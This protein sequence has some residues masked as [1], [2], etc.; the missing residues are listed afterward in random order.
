MDY[1]LI[2]GGY[3]L[4]GLIYWLINMF[5]RKLPRKNEDGAGW[6]LSLFWLLLWPFCFVALICAAI[7]DL[8]KQKV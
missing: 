3:I 5:I 7:A 6:F 2:Y 8:L 1:D 4:I